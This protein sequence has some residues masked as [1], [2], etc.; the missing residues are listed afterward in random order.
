MSR[1]FKFL[2]IGTAFGTIAYGIIKYKRDEK[3]KEKVDAVVEKAE[4]KADKVM[5]KASNFVCD[6][7]NLF[8]VGLF[9]ATIVPAV[10]HSV[11]ADRRRQE[12]MQQAY[13]DFKAN[14]DESY[15]KECERI[16]EEARTAAQKQFLIDSIRKN[17]EDY[18][19]VS[20]EVWE[21]TQKALEDVSHE[22]DS[23]WKEE[24]RDTWDEVN[25]LSK[26]IDLAPGES[27]MIEESRQLGLDTDRPVI[28]HMIYGN[29]CYPPE[30]KDDQFIP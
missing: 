13:E 28:S 8:I 4:E 24:Y 27:Y 23:S 16:N 30:V 10:I 18:L 20:K 7:P 5:T 15:D 17:P 26:R 14:A 19:V 3:F 11:N 12:M 25:E 21:S 29:G 1:F 2:G 9:T 6:H 22:I